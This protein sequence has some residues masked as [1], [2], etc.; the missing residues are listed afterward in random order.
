MKTNKKPF[1]NNSNELGGSKKRP[2][3]PSNWSKKHHKHQNQHVEA[4]RSKKKGHNLHDVIKKV[5]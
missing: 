3:H 2:F 5:A 1:D 4:N